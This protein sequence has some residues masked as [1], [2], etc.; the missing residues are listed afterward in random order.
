MA[1][2]NYGK[3]GWAYGLGTGICYKVGSEWKRGG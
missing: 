3:A 1:I 2:L